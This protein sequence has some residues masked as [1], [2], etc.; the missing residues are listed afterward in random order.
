MGYLVSIEDVTPPAR[1]DGDPWT[2]AEVFEGATISGPWELIETFTVS[3]IDADPESPQ[4]RAFATDKATLADGWYQLWF[5]DE[6]GGRYPMNPVA[7][8]PR[9]FQPTIADIAVLVPAR[10]VDRFGNRLGTFTA[11][12]RPTAIEVQRIIVKATAQVGAKA[13]VT[14]ES[15]PDV[16]LQA[17]HLSALYGAMLVELTY[18]PEQIGSGRSPYPEYKDLYDNGIEALA[19]AAIDRNEGGD[20]SPADPVSSFPPPRGFDCEVW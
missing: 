3:P 10:T 15:G 12:T 1:A 11:E 4:A 16:I 18:F 19:S 13:V 9:L 5:A 6:V 20:G 7:L 2:G 14:S 17:R 8:F